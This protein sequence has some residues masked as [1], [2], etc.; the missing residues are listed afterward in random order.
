MTTPRKPKRSARNERGIGQQRIKHARAAAAP[1][2]T[3]RTRTLH[4]RLTQRAHDTI[5]Q[6]AQLE[7]RTPSDYARLTLAHAATETFFKHTRRLTAGKRTRRG[8]Q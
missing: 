8:T 4:V 5:S 2:I 3:P 6:A 7:Q 1:D